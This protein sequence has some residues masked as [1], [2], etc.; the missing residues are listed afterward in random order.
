MSKQIIHAPIIAGLDVGSTKVALVAGQK[1]VH[2]ETGRVSVEIIGAASVPNAGTRQGVVVNIEATTESIRKAKEEVELMCGSPIQE[3]WIG[4]SGQHVRS[5]DSRGMVAIKDGEVKKSDIDRVIDAAKAIAVPGDR[6]VLHVIP[7]DYRVDENNDIIDP[8]GMSGVRLESNVHIVTASHTAMANVLK[9][10]E[11]AGLK[12]AGSVLI[13]LAASMTVLSSDEKNLG[14]CL[15]DIGG[16]NCNL[17]YFVKGSVAYTSV[18]PIGGNHF[19]NDIAVGLRTTQSAAEEIKKKHGCALSSLV[20]AESTIEVEGVG[21]R[22]NRTVLKKD[23]AEVV[24]PR[25]EEMMQM[26]LTDIQLSGLLPLLGSGL[27]IT[28]G[29]SQLE[30][31]VELGEFALDIPVR[32][33]SPAVMGALRDI[34]KAPIYAASV[35]LLYYGAEQSRAALRASEKDLLSSSVEVVSLKIKNLLRDLF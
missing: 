6:T 35:G 2:P 15:A 21:G 32:R 5:F 25:A 30:G 20:D 26:I 24:E 17:V 22:K 34:V 18:L 27:V 3:V 31:L 9:C 13:P 14:V 4:V 8:I 10:T 7:R 23:L 11:R 28:G 1:V 29:A 12:V 16:G 33:G 19:S